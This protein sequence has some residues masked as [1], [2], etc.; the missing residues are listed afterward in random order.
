MT[1]LPDP[2]FFRTM[3]FRR[4]FDRGK[5]PDTEGEN[6]PVVSEEETVEEE[7]AE[8]DTSE[9][10][11]DPEVDPEAAHEIDWLA[12]ARAVLPNGSSTGTEFGMRHAF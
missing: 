3:P 11:G 9:E 5:R 4:F 12:R 7:T 2:G 6:V 8:E 1:L 10:E